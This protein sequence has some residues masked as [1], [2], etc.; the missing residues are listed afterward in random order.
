M[1]GARRE[2][3]AAQRDDPRDQVRTA[4]GESARQ[5]PAEA[6][7]DDLDPAAAADGDRLD[8]RLSSIAA[9]VDRAADVGADR[10]AVGA[11]AASPQHPR[12]SRAACCR[13]PGSPAPGS[14]AR[15]GGGVGGRTPSASGGDA[16]RATGRR[17]ARPR[18]R[19]G[20]RASTSEHARPAEPLRQEEGAQA[21]L[22]GARRRR[23][24]T[25][26]TV[27]PDTRG[28]WEMR[29]RLVHLA[30]VGHRLRGAVRAG[31]PRHRALLP[32][33]RRPRTASRCCW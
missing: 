6:V 20:S 31:R 7:A 16:R 18:P 25:P 28:S 29:R 8:A 26:S 24:L 14:P 33:V 4:R 22:P 23:L 10:R 2:H 5:H 17:T 30:H 19:R 32:D 9:A 12:P 11:E 13:R 3:R 1:V 15:R 27:V 21:L